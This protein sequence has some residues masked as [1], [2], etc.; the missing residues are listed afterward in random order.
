[1][2]TRAR[3]VL[4]KGESMKSWAECKQEGSAHY[5]TGEVEP[6][7]LFRAG[8][9]FHDKACSDIIK[10]AFRSRRDAN[11]DKDLLMM[12]MDKIIHLAELLKAEKG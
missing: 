8:N 4:L 5:K 2:A 12:N 9:M 7:D 11:I 6:I 10:Y 3:V 1:M